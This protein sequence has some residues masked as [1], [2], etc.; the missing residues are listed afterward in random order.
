MLT[1]VARRSAVRKVVNSSVRAAV[2]QPQRTVFTKRTQL[3]TLSRSHTLSVSQWRPAILFYTTNASPPP[4]E[5]NVQKWIR[6]GKEMA[7]FYMNGIKQLWYNRGRANQL[8]EKQNTLRQ[9]LVWE[10]HKF[11]AQYYTDRLVRFSLHSM[12]LCIF[13]N[14]PCFN[15]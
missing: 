6:I 4:N 2:R 12:S 3:K 14:S 9:P 8:I 13:R 7:Q 15:P 10:E 1:T 5:T 11:V